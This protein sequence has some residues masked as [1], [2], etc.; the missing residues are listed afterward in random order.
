MALLS[1]VIQRG[2]RAAQ[3]AGNTVPA[4][5]I[6]YV[7]DETV[8]E[9]S[10]GS[11]WEDI[12]D[13]GG[14]GGGGDWTLVMKTTDESVQS[15]T[16]LSN[17]TD[18]KF[19]MSANTKYAVRGKI[20]VTY[21]STMFFKSAW[22]GP[23]SPTLVRIHYAQVLTGGSA[24]FQETVATS[25]TTLTNFSSGSSGMIEFD[26]IIHNGANAGDF[27]FQWAQIVST[28]VNCTVNAGSWLEWRQVA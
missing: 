13:A 12:S 7:T 9:R 6:Y 8:T 4:G 2:T 14:G 17:D 21:N 11:A 3:P 15:D 5:T 10:T 20:Y 1:D 23:A 24:P 26:A 27:T 25:L 28:A 22:A 18:L 16:T 19:T